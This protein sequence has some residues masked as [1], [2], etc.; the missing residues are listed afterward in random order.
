VLSDGRNALLKRGRKGEATSIYPARTCS[1]LC[2]QKKSLV[3]ARVGD[4][5]RR[6]SRGKKKEDATRLSG[7]GKERGRL[8][9]L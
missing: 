7:G 2:G 9:L 3:L 1:V 5:N 6:I 4:R 8:S